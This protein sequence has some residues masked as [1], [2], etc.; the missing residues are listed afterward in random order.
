MQNDPKYAE[1][2]NAVDKLKK[3]QKTVDIVAEPATLELIFHESKSAY[4]KLLLE[5]E[6]Y[7]E[8]TKSD[9]QLNYTIIGLLLVFITSL[10]ESLNDITIGIMIV[11]ILLLVLLSMKMRAILYED[12]FYRA[13]IDPIELL[14]NQLGESAEMV[15]F[16]IIYELAGRYKQT[17]SIFQDYK[18]QLE[19][20][21]KWHRIIISMTIVLSAL[22]EGFA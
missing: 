14:K 22:I 5:I 18:T 7:I 1:L 12:K 10:N 21:Q 2:S 16:G 19:T 8:I 4:E 20:I 13:E 17:S 9:L 6:A 15:K 3:D 11:S